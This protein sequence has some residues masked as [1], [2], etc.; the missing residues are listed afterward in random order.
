[1]LNICEF[2]KWNDPTKKNPNGRV[3]SKNKRNPAT[4]SNVSPPRC[5][6]YKS[7]CSLVNKN[8]KSEKKL[9]EQNYIPEKILAHKY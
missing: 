9:F 3:L 4:R 7:I 6:I 1:M 2:I 5:T 8:L